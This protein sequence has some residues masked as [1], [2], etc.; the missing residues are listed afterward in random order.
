MVVAVRDGTGEL[1]LGGRS[2]VDGSASTAS[3]AVTPAKTPAPATTGPAATGPAAT[4]PAV[5]APASP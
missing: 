3:N 5:P 2:P 4:A 1:I